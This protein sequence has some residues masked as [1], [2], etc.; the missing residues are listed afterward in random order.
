VFLV[1]SRCAR[2]CDTILRWFLI[3]SNLWEQFAEFL[4]KHYLI[5]LVYSTYEP[6]SV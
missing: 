6:L 5:A 3:S 1:N 2:F 4:N